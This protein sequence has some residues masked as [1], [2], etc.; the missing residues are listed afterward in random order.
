MKRLNT[1]MD[2]A[3]LEHCFAEMI[4]QGQ[5]TLGNLKGPPNSPKSDANVVQFRDFHHWWFLK[6]HGR[7]RLHQP[8]PNAFL[9]AT[10]SVSLCL[11]LCLSC[12]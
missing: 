10:L 11:C 8:C 5:T 9:G 4:M 2:D 3:M 12:C 6:K 7:P 1:S